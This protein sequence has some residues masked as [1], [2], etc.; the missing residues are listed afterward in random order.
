MN[1]AFVKFKRCILKINSYS[2]CDFSRFVFPASGVLALSPCT[3]I[4]FRLKTQ[5]FLYGLAV[6]PH[7]SGENGHRKGNFS[8]TLFRME[9]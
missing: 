6:H 8:K 7:V 9:I 1:S 3:R 2:Y 4:R 5:L